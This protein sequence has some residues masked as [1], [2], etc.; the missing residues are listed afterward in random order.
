MIQFKLPESTIQ[1]LIASLIV[2]GNTPSKHVTG[3]YLIFRK[4]KIQNI[5]TAAH[6]LVL[7]TTE[8][9]WMS[10][11]K[12]PTRIPNEDVLGW[13]GPLPQVGYCVEGAYSYKEEGA[14]RV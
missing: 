2:K 12:P 13:I 7:W 4:T 10:Q 3:I 1:S 6:E 9:H 11:G 14:Y 8:G 5:D